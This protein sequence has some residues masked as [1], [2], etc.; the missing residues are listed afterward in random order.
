[1]S[2]SFAA[3][4]VHL[5]S[6]LVDILAEGAVPLDYFVEYILSYLG[7]IAY[8]SNV[9]PNTTVSTHRAAFE[10]STRN[11]LYAQCNNLASYLPVSFVIEQEYVVFID[12][13][14]LSKWTDHKQGYALSQDLD[15]DTWDSSTPR[16]MNPF[17]LSSRTTSNNPT[18]D[19]SFILDDSWGSMFSFVFS[20]DT[21]VSSDSG[22]ASKDQLIDSLLNLFNDA[23][24]LE[25]EPVFTNSMLS[26][27]ELLL[28]E[29]LA[30]TIHF[31]QAWTSANPMKPHVSV[32]LSGS[33]AAC[34]DQSSECKDMIHFERL[35][36]P[37]TDQ[38]SGDCS[39]LD[40]C[41]K[42][43]ACKFVHYRIDIP[44]TWDNAL[45]QYTFE[46][47]SLCVDSQL[48]SFTGVPFA[49]PLHSSQV[50]CP[51][52]PAQW[53]HA[54]IKNLNLRQLGYFDVIIADPP[55]DIHANTRPRNPSAGVP[56]SF[57]DEEMLAFDLS[58]L[59]N[60]GLFFL[61]ATGRA[62]DVGRKC[63]RSWGYNHIEEILWIKTNQLGRT[64]CTGRTGHWLNH[65]KEH[66]LMGVK[67][68]PAWLVRNIDVDVIVSVA[69]EK[70][71]KPD[72]LYDIVE[73]LAGASSRKLEL[74]GCDHNIR[75][76][77][78][79]IGSQIKGKRIVQPSLRR[80]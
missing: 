20:D 26:E 58:M 6:Y 59:Q 29:P 75:D 61:W 38:M 2:S 37:S 40:T 30:S 54:N 14:V 19:N 49:V 8:N 9:D 3:L 35:V 67:G 62:L 12:F 53:L 79:T 64:I 52:W 41:Y 73:R 24:D 33:R 22:Y 15:S 17:K 50:L 5:K 76:G 47:P 42:G 55:W 32:C 39:Y 7:D 65:S 25:K 72:E 43:K 57:S 70:G 78:L 36:H 28:S 1:M 51:V 80:L 60:D 21:L 13:E 77:W 23:E 10:A 16:K 34:G 31:A 66:L 63:L 27:L 4:I 45:S 11:E 69:R 48:T 18:A 46:E 56:P 74:F 71:R 68:N 44:S